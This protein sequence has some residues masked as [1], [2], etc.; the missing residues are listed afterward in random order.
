MI[1][2]PEM[3]QYKKS[4][5]GKRENIEFMKI[6]KHLYSLQLKERTI[7]YSNISKKISMWWD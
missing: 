4:K 2:T 6:P 7:I 3:I 1:E 5:E